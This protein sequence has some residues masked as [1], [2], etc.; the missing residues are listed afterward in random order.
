MY[1]EVVVSWRE[2][3]LVARPYC[4]YFLAEIWGDDGRDYIVDVLR[5]GGRPYDDSEGIDAILQ[6][7]ESMRAS[8]KLGGLLPERPVEDC[9]IQVNNNKK[10]LGDLK[11]D[12]EGSA[13]QHVFWRGIRDA[14]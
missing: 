2:F 7:S 4:H 1:S 11:R 12:W 8:Y 9:T 6:E 3:E 13:I 5:L 14:A 10:M